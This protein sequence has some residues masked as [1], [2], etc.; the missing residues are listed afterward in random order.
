MPTLESPQARWRGWWEGV[1]DLVPERGGSRA[2]SMR[3]LF[4]KGLP[5]PFPEAES[6]VMRVIMPAG[7]ALCS[8]P[9]EGYRASRWFEGRWRDVAE[10]DLMDEAMTG[11]DVRFWWDGE[12]N[13]SYRE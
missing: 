7:G 4:G 3:S 11:K 12:D 6:S 5:G 10:W 2:F 1:V 8:E 13:F 9:E